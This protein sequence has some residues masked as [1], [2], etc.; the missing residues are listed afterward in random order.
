MANIFDKFKVNTKKVKIDA[1]DGAE[2]TIQE[3]TVAQSTE[4]QKRVISG[5]DGDGKAELNYD[6]LADIKL[7][8]VALAMV[9]PKLTLEELKALSSTANKA[10]D[11]ISDAIDNFDEGK[12]KS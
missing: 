3:L 1:L 6:E 7:E 9:E 5:I 2:I 10:I 11:E 12:K 4:F 8:K